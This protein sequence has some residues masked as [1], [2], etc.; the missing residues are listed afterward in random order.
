MKFLEQWRRAKLPE[1]D[2]A[3]QISEEDGIRSLH[4][5][6]ETVQSSMRISAP[7]DLVLAYTRAMM[8]F[9]LFVPEPSR[10]SMIGLGGG[11]L[12]KFIF[13]RL[14]NSRIV[15]IENNA[16]V[17][18][19]AHR[20]FHVP[21]HDVR[22]NIVQADGAVWVKQ[23]PASSD[24]LLVDGYDGRRQ[25]NELCSVNFYAAA[26]AALAP[27]GVLVVNLWSNDARF[28]ELVQR[29]EAAFHGQIVLTPA[30]RHGNIIA[31]A[32]VEAGGPIEWR[33]LEAC[34]AQLER[35]YGLEFGRFVGGMKRLNPHTDKWLLL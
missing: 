31:I 25:V 27:H 12:A 19:A 20:Q 1:A 26:A 9:L 30:L 11:S 14:P 34:A 24:V 10:V 6:S 18:V 21:Q 4:L 3:V 2:E 22:L 29:I 23:H 15:A 35:Q 28:D 16:Q 7:N 5:G 32:F 17:I 13:H 8:C 33:S